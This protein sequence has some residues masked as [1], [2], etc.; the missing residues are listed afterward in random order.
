MAWSNSKSKF[1]YVSNTDSKARNSAL[2][3]AS[4][5]LKSEIAMTTPSIVSDYDLI[6]KGGCTYLPNFFC[7]TIDSEIFN[8][9]KSELDAATMIKWSSH[10]KFENPEFSG[11]FNQIVKQMADHFKVKVL[12]TRL[13]YY[14]DGTSFKPLHK[15]RHAYGEGVN[16]I[17]ENF[18]MG[19]SFGASRNLDFVHD[20]SK[21]KFAFPQNNGDVFAF[22]ADINK[23]FLHGIPKVTQKILPRFS[24]IAWGIK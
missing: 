24:I 4:N 9:L 18:T 8:K 14:A 11:T 10:F 1:Q 7:K 17:E 22:D 21:T 13:N 15:D 5:I 20:E 3:Y 19:A 16:R 23:K 6:L 2:A 12:Q